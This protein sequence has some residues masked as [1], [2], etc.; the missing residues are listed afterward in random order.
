MTV[1][2]DTNVVVAEIMLWVTIV[3]TVISG[4]IYLWRNRALYLDDM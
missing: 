2:I 3:L 4:G 1:V